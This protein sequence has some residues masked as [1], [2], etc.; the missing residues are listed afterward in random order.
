MSASM[1]L[2]APDHL[3]KLLPLVTACQ[4]EEGIEVSDDVRRAALVPLL[5][6]IPHGTIYLIGPP[7]SP[8]GYIVISFGWSLEFGGLDGFI[9]ELF[10]RR[11]VRGRGIATDVLLALPKALAEVGLRAL[12][13][14]V[15]RTNESARKLYLRTGFKARDGYHLMTRTF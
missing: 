2:A 6:G 9:D 4:D 1:T 13:L 10:I 8:I 11:A 3:E 15:A 14:E 5:E 7:R 12:H